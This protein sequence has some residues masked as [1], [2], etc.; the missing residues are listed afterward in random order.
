[1]NILITSGGK[2]VDLIEG[3]K[4]VLGTS[5]K[6]YISDINSDNAGKFFADGLCLVPPVYDAAYI[7][8][9]KRIVSEK[10]ITL[11][12]SVIDSDLIVL[13]QEK[14][15]F[16]KLGCRILISDST[17][18]ATSRD[19][20]ITA[21]FLERIGV[22]TPAVLSRSSI[23]TYPVFIKPADGSSSKHAYR[24]NTA[25]ELDALYPRVPNALLQEFVEGEEYSIDCLGDLD[26]NPLVIVPR[27]RTEITNG[28]STKSVVQLDTDIIADCKKIMTELKI[29]GPAVLQCIKTAEGNF[30]IECNLRFGG[31]SLVGS[32]AGGNFFEKILGMMEGK[33]Y[34]F[35][36]D[37]ITDGFTMVAYLKHIFYDSSD[38]I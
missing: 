9:L 7:P 36:L 10:N 25:Q 21:E 17:A 20:R 11:L 33:S 14:E 27:R 19:K 8:E 23:T 24:I 31:G 34:L 6:V 37:G 16:E 32:K 18:I 26:G 12:F 1:M 5:G 22:R 38:N 28:I 4:E 3:F 35:S 29:V 2:R 13:A 30:F 15:A